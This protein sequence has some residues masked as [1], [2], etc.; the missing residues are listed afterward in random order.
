MPIYYNKSNILLGKKWLLIYD[1]AE[2]WET[3]KPFWPHSLNGSIIVTS[4]RSALAQIAGGHEIL[5]RPLDVQDGAHLL[6]KHLKREAEFELPGQAFEDARE[7]SRIFDSLPIA[8]AHIAGYIDQSG[9]SMQEFM[10]RYNHWK[11]TRK[12][13]SHSTYASYQYHKR[14]DTVFDIA[15]QELTPDATEAILLMSM[16]NPSS[17]PEDMLFDEWLP[18]D[19]QQE[20]V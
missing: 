6:L 5:L 8:L 11:D 16:L 10:E 4:Q 14:L 13:W 1:E 17:I 20:Y 3:L 18:D 15:L 2:D 7:I 19:Q 9:F 12:I